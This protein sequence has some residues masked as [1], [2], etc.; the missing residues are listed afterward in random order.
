MPA[1]DVALHVSADARLAGLATAMFTSV[2]CAFVD[3][4]ITQSAGVVQASN[5]KMCWFV[6]R[7]C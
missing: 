4:V 2:R 7:C 5:L 1:V 3:A 6:T